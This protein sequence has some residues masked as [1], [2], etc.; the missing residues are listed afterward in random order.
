MDGRILFSNNYRMKIISK[1]NWWWRS[2]WCWW[3][4]N[5]SWTTSDRVNTD[6]IKK[7][8][9]KKKKDEQPKLWNDFYNIMRELRSKKKI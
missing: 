7:K 2:K 6:S 4:S 8:N 3:Y 1:W 5:I 9:D